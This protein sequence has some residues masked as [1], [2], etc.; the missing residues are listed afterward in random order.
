MDPER[1]EVVLEEDEAPEEEEI[2][3]IPL[4]PPEN[5]EQGIPGPE[6][7]PKEE[8]LEAPELPG[9]V[10]GQVKKLTDYF[11]QLGSLLTSKAPRKVQKEPGTPKT[12]KTKKTPTQ[13]GINK[14]SARK[15]KCKIDE[16]QRAKMELA[17][18]N[19]LKKKPPD[20]TDMTKEEQQ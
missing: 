17:L 3:E 10:Q 14:L 20:Q 8:V 5:D 13:G 2:Q 7:G 11:N 1:L 16:P 6:P 19:F 4:K 15:K 12:P 18:R 9:Q